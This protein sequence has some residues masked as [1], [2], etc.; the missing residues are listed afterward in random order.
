M[1][2]NEGEL[3]KPP[4]RIARAA[5]SRESFVRAKP[6]KPRRRPAGNNRTLRRAWRQCLKLDIGGAG[7]LQQ[8]D[9]CAAVT[10]LAPIRLDVLRVRSALPLG[11]I[12]I[13][14]RARV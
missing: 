11:Q 4:I 10:R 14:I 5:V 7:L 1:S 9:A 3:E 8:R 12:G 13:E 6:R 2:E